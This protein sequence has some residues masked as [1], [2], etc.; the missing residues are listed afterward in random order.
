[1]STPAD[2]INPPESQYTRQAAPSVPPPGVDRGVQLDPINTV[3]APPAPKSYGDGTDVEQRA[4]EMGWTPQEE[5]QESHPNGQWR[6]AEEFVARDGHVNQSKEALVQKSMDYDALNAKYDALKGSVQQ[7]SEIANKSYLAGLAE[8]EAQAKAAHNEAVD[9]GDQA[10]ALAAASEMARHQADRASVESAAR[11]DTQAVASQVQNMDQQFT[12][13]NTWLNSDPMAAS[14]FRDIVQKN[15]QLDP[16]TGYPDPIAHQQVLEMAK[17]QVLSQRPELAGVN[18]N[19]AA[20]QQMTAPGQRQPLGNPAQRGP[21]FE[22]LDTMQQ[23]MCM[24]FVNSGAYGKTDTPEARGQAIQSYVN[25]LAAT[26][27]LGP[28]P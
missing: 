28:Q 5:F 24:S 12:M 27:A 3:P 2:Q 10:A 15:T 20:A 21:S 8:R 4:R 6:S 22:H 1:M 16:N 13:Q 7:L 14:Y 9:N 18:P 17:N 11:P 19:R 23:Q 25:E 26:G